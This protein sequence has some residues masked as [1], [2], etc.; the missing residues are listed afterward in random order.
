MFY[1]LGPAVV[2]GFNKKLPSIPVGI[3][4]IGNW[5]PSSPS[6]SPAAKPIASDLKPDVLRDGLE[7]GVEGISSCI[8]GVD[9]ASRIPFSCTLVLVF[10]KLV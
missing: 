3:A 8:G 9:D 10:S 2:F 1:T 5:G 4:S 6:V 7:E